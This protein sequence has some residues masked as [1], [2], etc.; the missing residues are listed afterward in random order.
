LTA[1]RPYRTCLPRPIVDHAI[2]SKANMAKMKEAYSLGRE[3]KDT[4]APKRKEVP[5]KS[6]GGSSKKPKK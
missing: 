1:K 2:A 5:G 4:K 6:A 3:E